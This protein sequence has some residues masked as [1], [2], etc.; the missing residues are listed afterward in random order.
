MSASAASSD[1]H[2][3]TLA[4]ASSSSLNQTALQHQTLQF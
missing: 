3:A 2:S 4:S 1:T